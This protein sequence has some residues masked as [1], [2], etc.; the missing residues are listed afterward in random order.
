MVKLA[1][2]AQAANVSMASVSYAF[3]SDPGKR[4]KLSS[5]TLARILKI[6][7]DMDYSPNWTARAF[8]Q[9][10]S[11][12]IALLMPERCASGMSRHYLGIF[13]GVSAAVEESEYNLSVFFGCG[14]KLHSN[15]QQGRID[16]VLVIARR[17]E[18]AVFPAI[19]Q[20]KM[21]TIFLNRTAP[22]C[23]LNAGSCVS[24]YRT[25]LTEVV[26][27]F[28]RHKLKK[29]TLFYRKNRSSDQFICCICRELCCHYNLDISVVSCNDFTGISDDQKGSGYIF[30]GSS[31]GIIAA[32]AGRSDVDYAM[33]ASP[34]INSRHGFIQKNLY[35]HDSVNIGRNGVQMLLDMIEKNTPADCRQLPLLQAN[36][37]EDLIENADFEF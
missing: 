28:V 25:W 7:A 17:D 32:L 20:L 35:Y 13:H 15:I 4:K 26:Q 6:A 12:N 29:C 23:C 11:Y 33:L 37:A 16:G 5:A 21:P 36:T 9:Q 18:S 3:S 24:D 30:C 8:A 1:D 2:I 19:A 22:A 10:K 34:E 31:P 27:K 14:H